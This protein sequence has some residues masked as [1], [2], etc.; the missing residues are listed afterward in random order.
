[1]LHS[2]D[3]VAQLKGSLSSRLPSAVGLQSLM[4]QHPRPWI[5]DLGSDLSPDLTTL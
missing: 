3:R 4:W 5:W 1:M 2:R